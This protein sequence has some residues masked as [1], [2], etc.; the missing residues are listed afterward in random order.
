MIKFQEEIRRQLREWEKVV[1]GPLVGRRL[2]IKTVVLSVIVI[3]IVIVVVVVVVKAK[4][5]KKT[6]AS[7]P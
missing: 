4:T 7:L 2:S 3:V 1:V 5:S 6:K